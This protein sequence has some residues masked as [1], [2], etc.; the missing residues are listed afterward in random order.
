M[1]KEKKEKNF[2]HKPVYP[3]GNK[4]LKQFIK[5]ELKYPQEAIDNKIEGVVPVRYTVNGKGD[6]TKTKTMLHLGHG[7]D[8]EAERLVKLLK[9]H[10][11]KNRKIR[12]TFTKT[13]NI[14]FKLPQQTAMKFVYKTASKTPAESAEDKAPIAYE[15]NYTIVN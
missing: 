11:P 2:I 5:Q 8:E 10:V 9:F 15:Y 13:L 12:V 3:G 14:R 4:A 1:K 6:V 7:C